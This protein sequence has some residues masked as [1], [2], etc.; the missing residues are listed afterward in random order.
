[1][2]QNSFLEEH[3]QGTSSSLSIGFTGSTWIESFVKQKALLPLVY[4]S[5]SK[6]LFHFGP[7]LAVSLVIVCDLCSCK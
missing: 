4:N 7:N 3:F 5:S 1:M 2:F 6:V